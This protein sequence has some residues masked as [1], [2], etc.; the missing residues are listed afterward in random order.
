MP[1]SARRRQPE[2]ENALSQLGEL[3]AVDTSPVQ[4]VTLHESA[5]RLAISYWAARDLVL[6]GH[7][8]AVRLPGKR[9]GKNL[10]RV[11][12]DVRDL[13]K[14]VAAH[15]EVRGAQETTRT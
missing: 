8:A 2:T 6:R 13:E 4:L 1:R 11:L 12:V 9:G 14:F 10:R 5:R 3:S 15:R 7:L